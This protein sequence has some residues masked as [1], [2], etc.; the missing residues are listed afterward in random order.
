MRIDGSLKMSF[1]M[2]IVA[3]LWVYR[4]LRC[5]KRQCAQVRDALGFRSSASVVLGSATIDE[6]LQ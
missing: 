4:L 6:V 1:G 3:K 2:Q 5:S